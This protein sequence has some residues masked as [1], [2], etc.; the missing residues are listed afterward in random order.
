MYKDSIAVQTEDFDIAGLTA[1]IRVNDASNGAIVTFTGIVREMASGPGLEA[2]YLEHYPG[3][4]EKALQKIADQ[5]R[6]RWELGNI[7]IVHRIGKLMLNENIVFIGV[8][9]AHRVAAFEAAQFIMD[10]LKRDAPF[11]KKEITSTGEH[12]VEAKQ[13][14]LTAAENWKK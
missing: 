6:E 4:T 1:Q 3:M 10:Y 14:D 11:W 2:M 9:S 8:G 12:W 7:V 5:A 13:T